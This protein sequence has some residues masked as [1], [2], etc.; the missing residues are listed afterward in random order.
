MLAGWNLRR[1]WSMEDILKRWFENV[2]SIQLEVIHPPLVN[3][4]FCG[5]EHFNNN[6]H[7]GISVCHLTHGSGSTDVVRPKESRSEEADIFGKGTDNH[8]G[9]RLS[10]RFGV[11][12]RWG[13]DNRKASPHA[14][15][16]TGHDSRMGWSTKVGL[17][18]LRILNLRWGTQT[19][20]VL[21]F[22]RLK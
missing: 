17:L 11:S 6:C 9:L 20:V 16:L 21:A 22:V 15:G 14:T 12:K 8:I 7:F 10:I 2:E 19:Y 18:L 5:E 4:D 13:A 3:C 1:T